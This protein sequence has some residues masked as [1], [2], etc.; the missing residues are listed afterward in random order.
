M[1]QKIKIVAGAVKISGSEPI[2]GNW[3]GVETGVAFCLRN[4]RVLCIVPPWGFHVIDKCRPLESPVLSPSLEIG[5]ESRLES[6]FTYGI[7]G[8]CASYLHRV[9]T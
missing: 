9:F 3:V 1:I 5:L 8:Y 7:I 4:H 6:R 2:T